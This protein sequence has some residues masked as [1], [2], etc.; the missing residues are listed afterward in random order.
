MNRNYGTIS[1]GV[2]TP[3]IRKGDDLASI[4][5]N[6]VQNACDDLNMELE[7]RDVIAITE[8][9]VAR[10][11]GNYA[12]VDDIAEDI[13]RKLDKTNGRT[14]GLV[15]P[16]LSRNRFSMCLKGIARGADKVIIQ[17]SFPYDE[18]G[19]HIVNEKVYYDANADEIIDY[20]VTEK[21]WRELFPNLKHEFTGVDYLQY[22]R[23]IVESEGA[24]CQIILSNF[25]SLLADKFDS[26]IVIACD[27]H[28]HDYTMDL[29]KA[30]NN[31]DI[32]IYSLTDIL[33]ESINNSGHSEYGLLGSN[34]AS[35]E[36]VKLFPR[37]PEAMDL[38]HEVQHQIKQNTGKTVEVMVYGD[39]AFK[40][41]QGKIWEL[42]DPVVSPAYTNGLIGTPNEV[43]IKYL[44]DNDY[45]NL[46][47]DELT[48]AIKSSIREKD[49]NLV[50]KMVSEGTTPRQ[51]TD[52]LGSLSDLTS[53][54]G[55]KGTPVVL[56][57]GYFDNYTND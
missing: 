55:D 19:N 57:K 30:V 26:N 8:S 13:R 12:T 10:S 34:K 31:H 40:D 29:L 9:I 2:R 50:G 56:I 5:V 35:N 14:V 11:Q 39:G 7:D 48:D 51:L 33:S 42:A 24:E 32:D 47:G 16:I 52:L 49:S 1:L 18:V 3:I 23:E 15:F 4:V 22:Y 25:A 6:S 53:G 27:I 45:A 54:S 37:I 36:S 38:V 28:T 44:A 20:Y 43:K 21:T 41:P 46:N 17:L